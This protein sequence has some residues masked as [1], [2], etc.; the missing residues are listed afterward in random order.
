LRSAK[1]VLRNPLNLHRAVALTYKQF[2][3]AF[4]NA[5]T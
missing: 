3:Y 5:V 4:A 2:R 1:P